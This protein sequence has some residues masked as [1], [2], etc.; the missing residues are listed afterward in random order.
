MTR[1]KKSGFKLLIWD[2]GRV[3]LQSVGPVD[4]QIMKNNVEW[5]NA[6]LEAWRAG[7][8][9]GLTSDVEIIRMTDSLEDRVKKLEEVVFGKSNNVGQ[10]DSLPAG[11][12]G[13]ATADTDSD[14][15]IL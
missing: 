12:T 7:Q 1:A 6:N 11:R 4:Q 8:P 2:D 14:P 13:R 15:E 5:L 3:V 10:Q 9:I